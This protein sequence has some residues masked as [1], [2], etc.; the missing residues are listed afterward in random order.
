MENDWK[1]LKYA[2]KTT[3]MCKI[4]KFAKIIHLLGYALN[5]INFENFKVRPSLTDTAFYLLPQKILKHQNP[6]H[7]NHLYLH[8][9]LFKKTSSTVLYI[10][11]F[12]SI[13]FSKFRT[14]ALAGLAVA[15]GLPNVLTGFYYVSAVSHHF[16]RNRK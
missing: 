2:L 8:S 13:F 6:G 7:S 10:W 4:T 11:N 1:I 3:L 12:F 16:S 5:L 9:Y 14:A 15:T